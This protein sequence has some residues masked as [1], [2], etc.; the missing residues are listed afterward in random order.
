MLKDFPMPFHAWAGN[1]VHLQSSTSIHSKRNTWVC[2]RIAGKLKIKVV[3]QIEGLK[4]KWGLFITKMLPLALRPWINFC[5]MVV[6]ERQNN[7]PSC[8]LPFPGRVSLA[9]FGN[10]SWTPQLRMPGGHLCPAG[11][12]QQFRSG[13]RSGTGCFSPVRVIFQAGFNFE[14]RSGCSR[15]HPSRF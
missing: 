6:E 1:A 7:V 12:R 5:A 15:S 11:H 4:I 14:I 13:G 3:W 10:C 2:L 8:A 9:D